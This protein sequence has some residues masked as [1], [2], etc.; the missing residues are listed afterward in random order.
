MEAPPL[1]LALL[2]VG[3][4]VCHDKIEGLGV[5]SSSG[6]SIPSAGRVLPRSGGDSESFQPLLFPSQSWGCGP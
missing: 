1:A 2:G 5:Q 6:K 3:V 4:W